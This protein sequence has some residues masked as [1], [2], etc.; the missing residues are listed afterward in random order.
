MNL[1]ETEKKALTFVR[2]RL[3]EERSLIRHIGAVLTFT[4]GCFKDFSIPDRGIYNAVATDI[5]AFYVENAY[6]L[7]WSNGDPYFEPFNFQKFYASRV[8]TGDIYLPKDAA[9]EYVAIENILDTVGRVGYRK[10]LFI[11]M[12]RDRLKNIWEMEIA[13]Q[14]TWNKKKK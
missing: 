11:S 4:E 8:F 7:D 10:H 1:T 6:K 9:N 14:S 12:R 2:N 3:Y 5:H 13:R